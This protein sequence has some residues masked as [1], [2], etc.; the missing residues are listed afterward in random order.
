MS[1]EE[2][3][4][5]SQAD[6]RSPKTSDVYRVDGDLPTRFN[7]PDCFRGY[8]KKA[9]HP[10]YRTTNQTYGGKKPT[11][12]EMPTSFSG[13]RRGFSEQ[14]V[15]G[16]MYGDH[17]FNTSLERSAISSPASINKLYDRRNFHRLYG[18]AGDETNAELK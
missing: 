16:G 18:G 1:D 15:R 13:T 17:G 12:H 7:N 9:V 10:M 3:P 11:V 2:G 4:T 8:S 5:P 14:L 6:D